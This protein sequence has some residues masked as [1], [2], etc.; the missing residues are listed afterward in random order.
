MNAAQRRFRAGLAV[1]ATTIVPA[2]GLAIAWQLADARTTPPPPDPAPAVELTAGDPATPTGLLSFRRSPAPIAERATRDVVAALTDP[3]LARLSATSCVVVM[4]GTDV[5]AAANPDLALASST[6]AQLLVA[7]VALDVLGPDFRFR[8]EVRAAP[9]VDGVVQGDLYLVGGGDPDL[10]TA[11]HLAS[12]PAA[13][14]RPTVLDGLADAVVAAG[15]VGVNGNLV[16]DGTRYDDE[17]VVPSWD[18]AFRV[19]SHVPYDALLLDDGRLDGGGVGLNPSQAAASRFNRLLADRGILIAGRNRNG[20]APTEGVVSLGMVE[21]APLVDIVADLFVTGDP[22]TAELLLKEIGVVAAGSGTRQGGLDAVRAK[23]VE[24]GVPVDGL[25]LEDGSGLSA[26]DRVSCR[27]LAALVAHAGASSPLAATL[28]A[29]AE[30]QPVAPPAGS[31]LA[32][33]TPA[34]VRAHGASGTDQRT[35]TGLLAGDDGHAMSFSLV[36]AEP[37]AHDDSVFGPVRD[38]LVTLLRGDRT[39]PDVNDLAPR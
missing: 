15:V 26:A 22:T 25:A 24:W 5:V 7:A 37:G 6:S 21:S 36:L 14:P 28:P 11:A 10:V 19:G 12:L 8:T 18:P 29:L 35:L 17:F 39:G 32:G 13:P 31:A 33:P 20:P 9:V 4:D 2:I 3:L 27:T 30:A 1:V 16:G 38:L 34:V 23:L